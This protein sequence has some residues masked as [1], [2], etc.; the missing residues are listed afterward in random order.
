MHPLLQQCLYYPSY[1]FII[2]TMIIIMLFPVTGEVS[3]CEVKLSHDIRD[4]GEE[5]ELTA[6]PAG[7]TTEI[8]HTTLFKNY[9]KINGIYATQPCL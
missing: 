7:T 5:I 9:E 4:L 8:L 1:L 6:T 3:E 2:I